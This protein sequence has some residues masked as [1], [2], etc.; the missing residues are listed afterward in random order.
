MA[1]Q[2]CAGRMQ[3]GRAAS[4]FLLPEHGCACSAWHPLARMRDTSVPMT[5]PQE[6][7]SAFDVLGGA[8][9]ISRIVDG[10]Y[11]RMDSLP[12]AATV[13][14]MYPQDLTQSRRVLKNYLTEWLGGPALYS[15]ERG[16]PRLRARHLPFSIGAA[17]RDAWML[18][19]R[20]ALEE[21]VTEDA[22]RQV[23]IE[24]IAGVADWMRNRDPP[25]T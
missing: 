6:S 8:D 1:L 10:F 18:C 16:H 5:T 23:L 20:G 25:G 2:Q 17:E 13:R 11:Q 21:V 7:P 22:I 19:M 14:A 15:T 3:D 12:Q 24:H 4:R 9:A